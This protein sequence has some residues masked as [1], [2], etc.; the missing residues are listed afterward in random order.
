M[1]DLDMHIR[2][3]HAISSARPQEAHG[4]AKPDKLPRPLIG[5]G[6]TESD[7]AHFEDKWGRYKRSTLQGVSSQHLVD[8]LWACC[9]QSL[10]TAVYNSG[11]NS[12]S[13]EETL[14][15][16]MKKLAVRAQNTLVNIVKFLDMSQ[17]QEESATAYTARLKG[18]ASTCNFSI[19]CKVASCSQLT[20]YSDK[21][22]CHQLVRGLSDPT[23]QEQIMAHAAD[24]P[25]I[26]LE[27]TLKYV[28]AKEAGKRSSNIL[29]SAAGINRI[30]ISKENKSGGKES[31][32]KTQGPDNRKCGWCGQLGHGA[33]A[34][35]QIR[36][37]K[38]KSFNHTC[39]ICSAVGHFG[40]MCRSKKRQKPDLGALTESS[41]IGD[42]NFCSL[43]TCKKGRQE[44]KALPHTAYSKLQ[45]WIKCKPESHPKLCLKVVICVEGYEQAQ[46][47]SPRVTDRVLEVEGLP[48]TGAQ[49]TVVGL[50]LIHQMGLTKS[51]LIP[52]AHG[53][54]TANN[55][56][57]KLLGG[58]F[59][60]FTALDQQTRTRRTKQLCY[61]A[62]D[63]KGIYLSK[64]ACVDLGVIQKEFPKIGAVEDSSLNSNTNESF[65][66]NKNKTSYLSSYYKTD[67][68]CKCPERTLPPPPPEKL[69]FP[70]T[71]A[72][73]EKLKQWILD[74]Y[75]ASAFNQCE[76]QQL[77]LMK[78]SPPIKLHIDPKAQPVAIHKARPVPIHWRDQVLAELERDVRIG[79]LECVPIVEPTN[80]CSPM[81]ICPKANGSPRRTVDLQALNKVAV[82]QTHLA[83]PPFQQALAVPKQKTKTIV[84][85]WQG[86]HSV[87]LTEE[88]RQFTTFLTPW[89]KYR[90]K[91]CPQGFIAS[92]DAY[93]ARYDQIIAEFKDKT[94]YIDDTL[95]W[96]D[97]LE[98]SFF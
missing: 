54:S 50:S 3:V 25:D 8:Q 21:M 20:S 97:D 89:G 10:E 79:V 39:E 2:C 29:S 12:N 81:V 56:G 33:R 53:V 19:K 95:L 75:A 98:K 60:E 86:Y 45:G 73:R 82:R 67:R 14:M 31:S 4:A 55:A 80:W 84:D 27:T 23:I 64:S 78:G 42:G 5:E 62:E 16:T 46:I 94:K 77:P 22:V 15:K 48:D 49:L 28:E 92:G 93:N 6:I 76:H 11:V 51:E 34:P 85:A 9:E 66:I 40:S 35:T 24:N 52:L 47:R 1:K 72:N 13:D 63:I 59:M 87:P 96:S 61:V 69:P 71:N 7:W 37:E 91:T 36:R 57:L 43:V 74:R 83:E 41:N 32:L 44:Y 17:D 30:A 70:A 90:Y 18:Q 26:D 68:E 65:M 38:C 88:D 58:A